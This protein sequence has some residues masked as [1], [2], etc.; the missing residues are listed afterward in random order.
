ME[1]FKALEEA[2]GES[3]K[4]V[5]RRAELKEQAEQAGE[6]ITQLSAQLETA[7]A[8]LKHLQ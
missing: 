3:A 6:E 1:A 2:G 5:R 7:G 8:K 4:A